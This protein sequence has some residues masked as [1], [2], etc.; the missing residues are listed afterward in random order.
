M[1]VDETDSIYVADYGNHRIMKFNK[2][3]KLVKAVSVKQDSELWGVVVVGDEVMVC[4]SGYSCVMVYTKELEY[5]RQFV[6]PSKGPGQFNY[7]RDVSS[8]EHGN[9][10]V[11]VGR[12]HHNHYR[13]QVLSN[14]GEYLCSIYCDGNKLNFP[15]GVCVSGQYVY[16]AGNHN[17]SVYTTTGE[18]VTT[19]GQEGSNKGEYSY[20]W[21]VCTDKDGYIYVCDRNND[22]I[23]IL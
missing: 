15:R 9:L 17:I 18:Y 6:S 1:A 23:Q 4:D 20:P 2:E 19:L 14:D 3:M 8:D 11:S 5:V 22:R 21:G 7:I 12:S 10:Y 16:V 13:I